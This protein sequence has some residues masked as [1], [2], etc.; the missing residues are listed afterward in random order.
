MFRVLTYFYPVSECSIV[1]LLR[2]K[3]KRSFA[4]D[5]ALAIKQVYGTYMHSPTKDLISFKTKKQFHD[6][7]LL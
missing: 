2:L 3:R 5:R 7:A 6:S 4:R 1:S